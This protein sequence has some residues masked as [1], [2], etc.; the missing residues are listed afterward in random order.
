MTARLLPALGLVLLAPL[1]GEYLLGNV[2]I[3]ELPALPLLAPLYGGGA[4]LIREVARRTGRGWPAML[5]LGLAYGLPQAGLIDWSLF[6]PPVLAGAEPGPAATHLPALGL[7]AADALSFVVG[8][9]VWSIGVPIAIVEAW[10]PERAET[11][12]LGRAGTAGAAGLYLIGAAVILVWAWNQGTV[13]APAAGV[14]TVAVVAAG[15]VAGALAVPR[16]RRSISARPAPR[17]WLVGVLAF[18]VSG[19]FFLRDETWPGVALGVVLAGVSAVVVLFW[20]RRPG[21]GIRH[22]LALAGGAL[23]TYAWGGFVLTTLLG[24][25]QPVHLAGNAVL[26]AAAIGLLVLTVRRSRAAAG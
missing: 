25:A 24:R 2:P 11:P 13:H 23:L 15:L 18:V 17:P 3:T 10:M 20:S 22:R 5:V 16:R 4:L 6:A 26:A 8:H 9:A 1:V 7:N 12:W 19:V 14:A 21:W